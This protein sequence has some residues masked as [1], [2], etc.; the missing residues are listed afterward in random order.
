MVGG[1]TPLDVDGRFSRNSRNGLEGGDCCSGT[2]FDNEGLLGL[3]C[4]DVNFLWSGG[5]GGSRPATGCGS[6]SSDGVVEGTM[7]ARG[8]AGEELDR[9]RTDTGYGA[10][11]MTSARSPASKLESSDVWVQAPVNRLG[12]NN[13]QSTGCS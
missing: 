4:G 5:E 6:C 11:S 9:S 1:G 12:V 8:C 7:L 10:P 2:S 13:T 3:D